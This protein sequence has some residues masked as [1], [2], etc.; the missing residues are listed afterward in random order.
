MSD[1]AKLTKATISRVFEDGSSADYDIEI[2]GGDVWLKHD[3]D[4][5]IFPIFMWDKLSEKI[6]ELISGIET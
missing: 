2:K 5:V 1:A 4:Y 6:G 3:N